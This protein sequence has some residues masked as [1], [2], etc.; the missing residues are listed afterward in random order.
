MASA[1]ALPSVGRG[2]QQR[3]NVKLES[4]HT[5]DDHPHILSE[6]VHNLKGLHRGRANL[7]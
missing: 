1:D 4:S 7:I 3:T 5:I 2:D 6:A